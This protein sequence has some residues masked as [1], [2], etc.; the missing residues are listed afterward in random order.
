MLSRRRPATGHRSVVPER[1]VASPAVADPLP[2]DEPLTESDAGAD[3]MSLFARWFARA[4]TVNRLP[5]AMALATVG[6]D[7]APAVRMVLLKGTDGGGFVF[8]TNYDSDK[9]RQL[10]G[11]PRAALC[12]YWDE[13]GRQVRAEGMV[14]RT[15]EAES[16]AY[17]AT[18]PRGSQLSAHASAQSRPVAE[19]SVLESA[20]AEL[21]RRWSDQPVPRPPWWGGLRLRP[22][23]IEFWQ[24][25][26][27]RLHDRLCYTATDGGW[28]IERLQP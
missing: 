8:F 20:M 19:R 13:L 12:W 2:H 18:R 5:Q 14:S 23:R 4:E 15:S 16:D 21:D 11:H 17:F 27:D 28:Q 1:L 3:P 9:G 26:D 24:N 6:L 25:R 7:G 10:L 22:E